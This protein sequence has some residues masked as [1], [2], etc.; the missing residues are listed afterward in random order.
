VIVLFSCVT[1]L[2]LFIIH[3]LL[4]SVTQTIPCEQYEQ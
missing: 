2:L 1:V 3:I 4:D